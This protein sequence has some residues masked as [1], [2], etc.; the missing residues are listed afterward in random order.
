MRKGEVK[1]TI[2]GSGTSTGVP[3][4]GCPCE[5]CRSPSPFNKRTRASILLSH[6][7]NGTNLVIDTSPDFRA[8][9]LRHD[10]THLEYALFTHTHADHCHGLDDLRAFYFWSRKPV[11]CWIRKDHAK[12]FRARFSYVFSDT[13]YLGTAPQI[14]LHAISA[15]HFKAG[16][17]DIELIKLPHGTETTSAFRLGPF[18]YATDFKSFPPEAIEKWKGKLEVFVASGVQ[19]KEHRTHSSVP[20]TI[21]LFRQLEVK[22]GII[23][24]LSHAIDYERDSRNLPS[25]AEY[26]YDGLQFTVE[27]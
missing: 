19:F 7:E 21:E 2:L 18:A 4:I 6:I 11:D 8:Q 15:G 22:R 9:V 24:H 1:V 26:A 25:F 23:T 10:V 13:G 3:T 12:D 16:G 5:V 27:I 17:Y 20:E 14:K